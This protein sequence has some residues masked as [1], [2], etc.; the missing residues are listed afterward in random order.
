MEAKARPALESCQRLGRESNPRSEGVQGKFIS[1][2]AIRRRA[3]LY[4][5]L[6]TT[7]ATPRK[8][9]RIYFKSRPLRAPRKQ[10]DSPRLLINEAM[11]LPWY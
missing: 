5:I 10:G 6:P 8:E 2:S 7:H 4:V 11:R 1:H 9:S 3:A